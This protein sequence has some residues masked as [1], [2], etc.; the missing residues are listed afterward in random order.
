MRILSIV[1]VILLIA[2][3]AGIIYFPKIKRAK[4][5]AASLD[6]ANIEHSFL[7]MDEHLPIKKLTKSPAPFRFSR[8]RDI[9]LPSSFEHLD[10]SYDTRAFLDSSYT[11]GLLII[12]ND[13]IC[14][15][16]YGRSQQEDSQH[17]S[18]SMA[19]SYV[20]ALMGIAIEEGHIKDIN[21]TVDEYLP[22]LKG[23]GYE[24]VSIKDVLQMST[25]VKF[26]ETYGDP[27]SDI[28]RYWK[29][30]V[31]GKSQDKFATTLVNARPPGT[32]NEYIS[33]N[34]HVLGM[35]I[36]KATGK[37]L[38]EYLQTKIWDPLGNEHDAY[39]LADG[40]GM[41]M[42]LGGLNVSLRDYAKLGRLYLN[43]GN[44]NGKQIVPASWV[45]ASTHASEPHLLP[46]SE[47]S[48]RP[49]FG[50][51]Y[52]W[53]ILDGDEEEYMA[54]GVFNQYIYI[55]PTTNTIIVKNSANQN[56]Y[57]IDN[58]HSQ[59]PVHVELFRKIAHSM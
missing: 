43:Q 26:D 52:Q 19:K 23:S 28:Q 37:S 6:M 49:D 31:F 59:S 21:Q 2:V 48:S 11:Q 53:W 44:W 8:T 29:G 16:Q 56:F 50:Y 36:V 27:N 5:F 57:D 20:S 54:I 38:S 22:E 24:G 32:Y 25:G 45:E 40:K 3:I 14:Y 9:T 4:A 30:F 46:H 47:L 39:W 17:I 42:A 10:Q 55:N 18:W 7:H 34:T 33:I 1:L 41:E 35:L 15:E 51:G 58:P 13:S 12:Q